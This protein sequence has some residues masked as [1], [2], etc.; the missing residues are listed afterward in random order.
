MKKETGGICFKPRLDLN[1]LTDTFTHCTKAFFVYFVLTTAEWHCIHIH[2]LNVFKDT[3]KQ[4]TR[5]P[6]KNMHE[7][8]QLKGLIASY[9]ALVQSNGGAPLTM[10]S[11]LAGEPPPPDFGQS[12][13]KSVFSKTLSSFSTN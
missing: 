6:K 5:L 3:S 4:H 9:N 2:L 8:S 1:L 13:G 12:D 11:L 7:R 10:D